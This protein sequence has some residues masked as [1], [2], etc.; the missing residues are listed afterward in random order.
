ME[1]MKI[2]TLLLAFCFAFCLVLRA[3]EPPATAQKPGDPKERIAQIEEKLKT[4]RAKTDEDAGIIAKAAVLADLQ[5][6]LKEAEQVAI[7]K[8]DPEGKY[9][10]AQGRFDKASN[11]ERVAIKEELKVIKEKLGEDPDLA[12]AGK[13]F[14]AAKKE[15]RASKDEAMEKLDPEVLT[16]K[17][18]LNDLHK[19]LEN[20][21]PK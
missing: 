20:D 2:P 21:S 10:D 7:S 12:A 1:F 16:L 8:L 11:E 15:L 17:S 6:K 5:I 4:V 9:Q 19:Q 14:G 18:E 13:A 3:G